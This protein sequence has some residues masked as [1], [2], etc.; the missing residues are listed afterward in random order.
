MFETAVQEKRTTSS[1]AAYSS[2]EK[3]AG[4]LICAPASRG[5]MVGGFEI[6]GACASITAAREARARNDFMVSGLPF[7]HFS[8]SPPLRP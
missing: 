4:T 7:N 1:R 6:G 8:L 2:T 3:P 5:T